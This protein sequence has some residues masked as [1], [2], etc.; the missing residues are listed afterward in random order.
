[1]TM[2]EPDSTQV[3]Q[4][5]TALMTERDVQ[6]A[7]RLFLNRPPLPTEDLS[8]LLNSQP[9]EF[10]SWMMNTPEFLNRPGTDALILNMTKKIQ[11]FQKSN[12]NN[13]P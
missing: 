13:T 7:F 10:L 1:M 8:P 12:T 3:D 6:A 2:P 9:G 4:M 5:S 11:D